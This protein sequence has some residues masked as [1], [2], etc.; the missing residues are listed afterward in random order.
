[1]SHAAERAEKNCLNCGTTVV[2]RFCHVCGQENVVPKESFGKLVIHFFY[3]I[4]HFDSKFFDTLR[5]LL[6]RPGF[7][8]TEYIR[9][10]R[11]GYLNPVKMY[12]FT[13]AIFFLV[14]FLVAKPED[15]VNRDYDKPIVTEKREEL[16]K[17]YEKEYRK[18]ESDTTKLLKQ[19]QLVKDTGRVVTLNDLLAFDSADYKY[20]SFAE[21][22]SIQNT[23]SR[24]KRD[25]WLAKM[26][27]KKFEV[28]SGKKQSQSEILTKLTNVFLHKLPYLLFLSLPLF[29]LILKLEYVRRSQFFY[30][31]HAIFSTHHYIFSF[32]LLLLCFLLGTTY[33]YTDWKVFKISLIV[34]LCVWPIHLYIAMLNFYKQ[35]WF[36]TFIKFILLNIFG[37]F[38]LLLLFV[39]FLFIAFLEV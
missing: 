9:G 39:A 13:S 15:F 27:V 24:E 2:G 30:A 25:G 29:A 20:K 7:L 3:D 10:R 8:S 18:K 17:E 6:F 26:M 14:F 33:D 4:T 11:A 32:S 19:L 28:N 23:L 21:Y 38:I 22:D 16:I 35:G 1:V 37:F 31:D 36:K 5:Y 34:L 12:V